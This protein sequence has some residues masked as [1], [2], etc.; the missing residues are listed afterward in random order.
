MVLR[1]L[2]GDPR[3][4]TLSPTQL[5]LQRHVAEITAL[6]TVLWFMVAGAMLARVFLFPLVKKLRRNR[7]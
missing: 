3:V 7:R 5:Y 6:W 2:E 4:A 1:V